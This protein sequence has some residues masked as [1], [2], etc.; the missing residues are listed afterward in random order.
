M[1][2]TLRRPLLAVLV[3]VLSFSSNLAGQAGQGA[4]NQL[5]IERATADTAAGRLYIYGRGFLA[6]V[7][8]ALGGQAL[9]VESATA[10][11]IVALLPALDPGT[12]RLEVRGRRPVDFDLLSL[13]LGATGAA[14]PAGPTGSQGPQGPQGPQGV[15]GPAGPAGP[16]GA[17][18]PA[19][20]P[21]PEGPAGPQGLQGV[22]GPTGP[23]GPAGP[24]G[25]AGGS[26]QLLVTP[27]PSDF[28]SV[29]L[30]ESA[31][32]TLQVINVGATS[33]GPL[34]FAISGAASADYSLP[35]SACSGAVL[36]PGASCAFT[37]VFAPTAESLRAASLSISASPGG[38][39]GATLLGTGLPAPVAGSCE[40]PG[41]SYFGCDFYAAS[42]LTY[43]FSRATFSFGIAVTNPG[44]TSANV[45]I[46][47]GAASITSA[48]VAAGGTQYFSLPWV[49]ALASASGTG[50]VTDGAYR[51]QS[52]APVAVYQMNPLHAVVSGSP[53]YTADS[54][55]LLPV[56]R[57]TGN[58][59][60]VTW[61]TFSGSYPG[62]VA[63]VA[64]EDN[65]SV[66]LAG[67]FQGGGGF[68]ASGGTMT[69][70]RGDVLQ[71]LSAG[72]DISGSLV[73]AS[74]PVAVFGGHSCTNVPVPVGY[75]DHLEEQASPI[76]ALGTEHVAAVPFNA[77]GT[78]RHYVK[79]VGTVDGTTLTYDPVQPGAPTS[80]NAGES[81]LFEA[82]D[83][84]R[85][86]SSSPVV[87]VQ[88][89]EGGSAFAGSLTAGDPAMGAVPPTHQFLNSYTFVANPS[90]AENWATVMAPAGA[91]ITID[92]TPIPG[93]S[94]EPVGDGTWAVAHVA[95]PATPDPHVA[96]GSQP[97]GLVVYGYGGYASYIYAGGMN[98]AH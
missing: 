16:P 4:P 31:Q 57:L 49:N 98:L 33:T 78:P 2:V 30:T 13:T 71:V 89:L 27:T 97:F 20:P 51:V 29:K 95:L 86:T 24:T 58:Y 77:T 91:T 84:I 25:P 72:T 8:V 85:I 41:D 47:Q 63:V 53:S 7:R 83:H 35:A 62:Y 64:T 46:T 88:A 74:A 75:C 92:G 94:F 66:T 19:G 67:S 80:V 69:L 55:L 76:E 32:A 38:P 79:I 43:E 44:D 36:S 68:P 52:D 28:G 48:V 15:A 26:S 42:L 37:V 90:W 65:T 70:N 18:G 39:A 45:S 50:M 56:H 87:V 5:V 59:R 11:A 61:P 6:P 21:G 10:S 82:T 96:A 3:V 34:G 54:S 93:A 81:I 17:T 23:E 60:A 1:R 22:A 73:T 14:G 40:L 12:Y 9:P